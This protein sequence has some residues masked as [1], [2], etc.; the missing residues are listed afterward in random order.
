MGHKTTSDVP[1]TDILMPKE[2]PQVLKVKLPNNSH[3]NMLIYS[4]G[5]TKEYLTHI[6][7]VLRIIDQKGLG[8]KCRMLG[9]VAGITITKLGARV[10]ARVAKKYKA[11]IVIFCILLA[12]NRFSWISWKAKSC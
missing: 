6:V 4:R 11:Q 5:N 10:G 7:A 3:L 8:T 9:I 12:V 1:E 2:E